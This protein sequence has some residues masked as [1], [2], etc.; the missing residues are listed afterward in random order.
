MAKQI[1]HRDIEKAV[2]A[3]NHRRGLTRHSKGWLMYGDIKG[4][5]HYRPSFYARTMGEDNPA[6]GVVNVASLY[7]GKTMRET[8]EKINEA[9]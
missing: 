2:D 3:L 7:R 9:V 1:T 6:C 5:G 8:L 4:N